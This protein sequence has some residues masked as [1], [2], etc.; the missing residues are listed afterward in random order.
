MLSYHWS[1][2]EKHWQ[3]KFLTKSWH[4]ETYQTNYFLTF[5]LAQG[6][7]SKNTS[8]QNEELNLLSLFVWSAGTIYTDNLHRTSLHWHHVEAHITNDLH[9]P[10]TSSFFFFYLFSTFLCTQPRCLS[11]YHKFLSVFLVKTYCVPSPCCNCYLFH[12]V[13]FIWR[14]KHI[15]L[16][17][18]A[19]SSTQINKS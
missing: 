8:K 16:K 17:S 19:K 12:F 13:I 11:L 3:W 9:I 18:I 1:K 15:L 7:S 6:N 14:N 10:I 4:L 5:C 2:E